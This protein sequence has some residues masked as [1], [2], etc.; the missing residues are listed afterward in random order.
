MSCAG[1]RVWEF[2]KVS[3]PFAGGMGCLKPV[4]TSDDH[5]FS[6]DSINQLIV[7]KYSESPER[8]ALISYQ[9]KCA[10]PRA[11]YIYL[12]F[13]GEQRL[14]K[15][16]AEFLNE[17]TF[18]VFGLPLTAWLN[19]TIES[20]CLSSS[21]YAKGD[22][23]IGSSHF[24]ETCKFDSGSIDSARAELSHSIEYSFFFLGYFSSIRSQRSS[25]GR[26]KNIDD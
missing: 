11:A 9:P 1:V 8:T 6:L 21:K 3:G 23:F 10:S 26:R 2:A 4:P 20:N 18:Q 25:E 5:L 19:V 15:I 16:P 7:Q 17:K 24:S 22:V 12:D 14:L 13:D